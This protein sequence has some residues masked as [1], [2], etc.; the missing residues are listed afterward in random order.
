MNDIITKALCK[1]QNMIVK[2]N[3]NIDIKSSNSDKSRVNIYAIFLIK[4]V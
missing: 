3:F 4:Q 1:Y 2:G